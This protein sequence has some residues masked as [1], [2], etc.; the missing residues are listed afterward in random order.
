M[1][2][3]LNIRPQ[4]PRWRLG[5]RFWVSPVYLRIWTNTFIM[6]ISYGSQPMLEVW[7]A[8][9]LVVE[10]TFLFKWFHSLLSEPLDHGDLRSMFKNILRRPPES[11]VVDIW[12]SYK[13]VKCVSVS[14]VCAISWNGMREKY[15][16]SF[17]ENFLSVGAVSFLFWVSPMGERPQA[18]LLFSN[19]D[20]HSV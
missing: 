5:K 14:H 8:V 9:Y 16:R 10:S 6:V 11:G 15:T 7:V 20:V 18:P 4:A 2:D 13:N 17:L 1:F 3:I 19:N 12:L